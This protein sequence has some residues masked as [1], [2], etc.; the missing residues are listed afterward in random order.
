MPKD[1]NKQNLQG[2]SF[3][4]KELIHAN[5]HGADIRGADFSDANLTGS[6]FSEAKTGIKPF[7]A[8]WIF[9]VAVLVSLASGYLAALAG[10]TLQH[11]LHSDAPHVKTSA[12]VSIAVIVLFIA[13][14]FWKG[15]G[16]A[17]YTWVFPV[18]GVAVIIG[19]AAKLTGS[20]TGE[21]M[22]YLISY[23]FLVA[24]MFVVGCMARVVGGVLSS[25]IL[26]LIVAISGGMFSKSIGGGIGGVVMA[27]SC[28]QISK[29]A[30]KGAPGFET[31]RMIANSVTQ[32]FGTSFRRSN[33]VNVDFSKAK[34]R[35][36]DF[37]S[38]NLQGV[39]WDDTKPQNCIPR[40]AQ[41]S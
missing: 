29:R 19:V 2:Q 40:I 6:D 12:I 4:R 21:G 26:F 33:L 41:K 3:A 31:L 10:K 1:H 38:A 39:N 24:I 34:L 18:S 14:S 5:F 27:L 9:A 8:A 20:G 36:C 7:D 13:Y 30:L 35:N 37:T 32:R 17:I 11:M 22:L 23:C 28:A 16:K 25:T 15:V